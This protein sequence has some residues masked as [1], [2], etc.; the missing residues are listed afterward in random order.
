MNTP[1][2]SPF[3]S[4][5]IPTRN[6]PAVLAAA[7]ASVLAQ[8]F[9]DYE[10][11][12]VDD[13]SAIPLDRSQLG[14]EA[15]AGQRLRIVNIGQQ[16]RGRG[17]G[18][19]RDVGVWE[20]SGRYCAFLD[21][22]DIWIKNDHLSVAHDALCVGFSPP[23]LYLANQEALA[24]GS[25]ARPLWLYPLAVQLERSDKAH[26]QG[27]YLVTADELIGVGGFSHLNTTIVSRALFDRVGG[28]D[29]NIAYEEDLDFY[30]RCIDAAE[31]I[32]FRPD[33]VARHHV[34]DRSRQDNASTS[35]NYLNKMN[36]RLYLLNKNFMGARQ[37]VI[38]MYCRDYYV[39]T[40]KHIAEHYAKQGDYRQASHFARSAL[41]ARFSIKWAAYTAFLLGRSILP[42][43]GAA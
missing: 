35:V 33:I 17:P 2:L 8:D 37:R 12:V 3:F 13:G 39:S 6:R 36:M 30:L 28:I 22:D 21:D 41:G 23:E 26:Q 19:S 4:V 38:R 7:V 34:P 5:I 18:Y 42:G 32:S 11:V 16:M 43:S 27:R 14:L 1:R 9:D 31:G 40:T 29:E 15:D 24:A 20:S 10:I 25:D